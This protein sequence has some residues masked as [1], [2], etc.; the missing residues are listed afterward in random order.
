[1]LYGMDQVFR[2][3]KIEAMV[4]VTYD[5]AAPSY[6]GRGGPVK[7]KKLTT[8]VDEEGFTIFLKAKELLKPLC[9]R[10]WLR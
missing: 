10:T 7:K 6:F 8:K 4:V 3:I 9:S 2:L 5:A 1:M